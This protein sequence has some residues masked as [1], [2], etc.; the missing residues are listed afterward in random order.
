[1][2]ATPPTDLGNS[3]D[4]QV[5]CRTLEGI[6]DTIDEVQD[7]QY[8][9]LWYLAAEEPRSVEEALNEQCWREAMVSEMNSI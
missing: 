7:F 8:S 2:F 9:G 1:M 5:R 3:E 4:R 6:Y